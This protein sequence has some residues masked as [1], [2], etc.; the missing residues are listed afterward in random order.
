[1][2]LVL[3]DAFVFAAVG[4]VIGL[5]AAW[6]ITSPLS[7]FLVTGLSTTDPMS[8]V[9]TAALLVLVASSLRGVQRAARCGSTR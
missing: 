5:G 9:G 7:M 4:C 6:F 3:R 2:R 1:M 8:L